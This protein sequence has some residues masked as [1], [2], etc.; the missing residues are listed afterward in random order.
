MHW[1]VALL[2]LGQHQITE[3]IL[4]EHVKVL[5]SDEFEGRA[6]GFPGNEKAV[7]YLVKELT[8]Y[9]YQPQTQEFTFAGSRR[10][11]NVLAVL[12]G[13]GDEYIVVGAHLDHVG[14]KGQQV[15]GQNGGPKDG[16][17]IWNGADDN[18]SGTSTVLSLARAF[19]ERKEKPRRSIIFAFWNAEE[20]G[21]VGS[22]YWI[23]NPTR[24]IDKV[25]FNLNLDMVGRN[26]DRPVEVE[27]CRSAEGETIERIITAA[28][29]AEKLQIRKHE[30]HN[31]AM[32][33]SDGASFLRRQIP[34]VMFFT[35]WHEDY[36]RVTD[37]AD[38]IAYERMARIGRA[39]YRILLEVANLEEM[40]K[41]N[42]STPAGDHRPRLGIQGDELTHQQRQELQLGD[43]GG[44]RITEIV[45][46]GVA[47][48]A[49]LRV[50]DV[51][52]SFDGRPLPATDPLGELRRR[53][54]SVRRGREILL[55]VIRNGRRET[56]TVKW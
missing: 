23:R 29:E 20:A 4:R 54:G 18:A 52:V 35:Y 48:K 27:G 34:A 21:L 31:E 28:C 25:V 43:N 9:G 50:G 41:F 17:E 53:L 19:S 46:G 24:P 5:A 33:R 26:P 14:K 49:G 45:E 16:D 38:R 6:A 32:F 37:H 11:K 1:F 30:F 39:C 8:S 7:E 10:A 15:R 12:Q 44:V 22:A 55:E 13:T 36:H 56:L 3:E 2:L 51:L 40:P 47:E 42:A